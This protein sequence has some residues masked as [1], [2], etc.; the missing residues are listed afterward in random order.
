MLMSMTGNIP[1]FHWKGFW[2]LNGPQMG[3]KRQLA[4]SFE[5]FVLQTYALYFW[6]WQK[7]SELLKLPP[8]H[9]LGGLAGPA[10]LRSIVKEQ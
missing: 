10:P 7:I 6:K 5:P 4:V 1:N 2:G 3:P 9:G 8:D